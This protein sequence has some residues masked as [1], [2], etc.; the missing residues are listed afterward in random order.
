MAQ[1]QQFPLQNGLVALGGLFITGG[2]GYFLYKRTQAR[3]TGPSVPREVSPKGDQLYAGIETGGTSC[4]VGLATLEGGEFKVIQQDR[5]QTDDPSVVLEKIDT[6][7]AKKRDSICKL[8]IAA[9]GPLCLD[10]ADPANCGRV[11]NTPK[12]K[13]KQFHLRDFF[14]QRFPKLN[15]QIDTDV[16]AAA[17]FEFNHGGHGA[18]Q[19]LAYITV[20]TG[21]GV[22]LVVNK[23]CVHGLLH[24]EGGHVIVGR[25]PEDD[26]FEGVCPTHKNCLE[27][28]ITNVAIAKRLGISINDLPQ[29]QDSHPVWD[30]VAHYLAVVCVNLTYVV[31][32]EMIV[33]GGGVLLRDGLLERVHRQFKELQNEYMDDPKLQRPETYIVKPR[34]GD[35]TGLLAAISLGRLEN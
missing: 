20:G 22:G 25:L 23:K 3:S 17:V 5:F 34:H 7:L 4:R 28:F 27:G 13:W 8:G 14:Q 33:L 2:I 24:P 6:F 1:V 26:K 30:T 32:P 12:E 10:G 9:F 29:V 21:V 19:N 18:S 16:N 11:L 31:S 35:E 15:V